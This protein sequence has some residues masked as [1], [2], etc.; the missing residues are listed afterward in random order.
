MGSTRWCCSTST[1]SS[2]STTCTV[3]QPATS[4]CARWRAEEAGAERLV[5]ALAAQIDAAAMPE[6]IHEVGVTF[7]WAVS[8]IDAE[9]RDSLLSQADQRLLAHKRAAKQV[10]PV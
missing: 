4:C 5:R 10:Q 3:I 1:T 6:G 8:P 2:R 9:D 7:A